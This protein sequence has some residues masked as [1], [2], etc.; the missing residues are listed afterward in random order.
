MNEEKCHICGCRLYIGDFDDSI[1]RQAYRFGLCKGC[2][3]DET[4]DE[5]ELAGEEL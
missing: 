2:Y 1:D 5:Y 3:I 4:F